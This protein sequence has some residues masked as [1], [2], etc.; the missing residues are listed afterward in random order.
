MKRIMLKVAYDGTDYC[1]WQIQPR[2]KTI[3]SELNK[4]LS[5]LLQEDIRVIGASR[6]DSGVHALSNIAVFDT[7]AR[8]DAAKVAHALNQRLP[9]DIRIQE[10]RE[11]PLT[12][13]P[14]HCNSKKT[15]E[16]RIYNAPFENPITRRYAYFVYVPLDLERMKKAASYLIGEHDFKSFCVA[17]AK[18]L[19]TVRTIYDIRIEK[20]GD[21][22]SIFVSGNG[23]LFNMVRIIV[24]TLVKVGRGAWE[25]EYIE[26]I[27]ASRDRQKAGPTAPANGLTL[28][29]YEFEDDITNGNGFSADFG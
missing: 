5:S 22:I 25:P 24:G 14:R 21:Y 8:M 3:E 15:Y 28:Y 7:N 18:V 2:D 11:V 9:S 26:E 19:S 27:L 29:S 1:G 4:H 12:F 23:F 16:Y 17:K 6:T 20:Q 10:S 13:H